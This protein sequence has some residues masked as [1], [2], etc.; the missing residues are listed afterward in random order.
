MTKY[1]GCSDGNCLLRITPLQQH[2]NGGCR[3]LRDVPLPLRLA[4][5]RKLWSQ[6]DEIE[7]LTRLVHDIDVTL[8][9]PAAG[10]VPVIGDVFEII[11]RAEMRAKATGGE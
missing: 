5:Q 6:K 4:I 1:E 3:C 8:R 10:Y 2:T 7:R 9:V 11:D